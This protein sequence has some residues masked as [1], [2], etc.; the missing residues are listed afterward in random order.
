MTNKFMDMEHEALIRYVNRLDEDV[1]GIQR[2]INIFMKLKNEVM[3]DSIKKSEQLASETLVMGYGNNFNK[4]NLLYT[5]LQLTGYECELR[6]KNVTDNTKWLFSRNG[7]VIPWYYV[8]VDYLG[9]VLNLD[10]SFDRSFMSAARIAH[11]G[12]KL[13]YELENYYFADGRVFEVSNEPFK[14]EVKVTKLEGYELG[15]G[16]LCI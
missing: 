16:K 8:H 10:C 4:N 12:D 9:K 1:D 2:I 13:D 3:Y 6:Y 11:K 7:K 5:V 15:R 14:P